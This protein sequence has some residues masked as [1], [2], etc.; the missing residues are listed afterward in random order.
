MLLI[1][2]ITTL[3]SMPIK[4]KC[5]SPFGTEPYWELAAFE[6]PISR[7]MRIAEAFLEN[8]NNMYKKLP[9]IGRKIAEGAVAGGII[10]Y[11]SGSYLQSE[12]PKQQSFYYPGLTFSPSQGGLI[13]GAI[14]G[15]AGALRGAYG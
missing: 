8:V 4:Q 9:Y 13:G 14:G 1:L 7:G 5:G 10:G 6:N 11:A 3:L 12:T 2:S 15:A